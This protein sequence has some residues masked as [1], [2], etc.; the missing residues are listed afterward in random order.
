MIATCHRWSNRSD[1]ALGVAQRILTIDPTN[2]DAFRLLSELHAERSE[3]EAAAR[4]IRLGLDHFPESTTPPPKFLFRLLRI[5]ALVSR[6]LKRVEE[7]AR[8]DLGDLDRD[9]RKWYL[10]ATQYLAWYDSNF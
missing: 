8:S 2:F 1:E 9:K 10:W 6:R 5:G 3:H 7:E 4:F